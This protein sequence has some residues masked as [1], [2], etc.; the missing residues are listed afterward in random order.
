[1][2]TL[3][4]REAAYISAYLEFWP[5]PY[6]WDDAG[7]ASPVSTFAP[8]RRWLS[9]LTQGLRTASLR[10]A[11]RAVAA[12]QHGK[13]PPLDPIRAAYFRQ[14]AAERDDRLRETLATGT[15]AYCG[16]TGAVYVATWT[17]R[18]GRTRVMSRARPTGI[19]GVLRESAVACTCA[20]GDAAAKAGGWSDETRRR[21]VAQRLTASEFRALR[22]QVAGLPAMAPAGEETDDDA[23]RF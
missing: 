2:V 11:M 17:D 8:V 18:S 5:R 20:A 9:E 3:R 21:F 22:D 13:G 6:D 12:K 4:D 19:E 1:M 15:C 23:D 14:L 7:L 16:N 10:R